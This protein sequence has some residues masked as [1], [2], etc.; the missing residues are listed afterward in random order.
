MSRTL[1]VDSQVPSFPGPEA[2]PL[3]RLSMDGVVALNGQPDGVAATKKHAS[4]HS[5]FVT[6][7]TAGEDGADSSPRGDEPGFMQVLSP[8]ALALSE[9]SGNNLADSCRNITQDPRIGL[10][11]FVSGLTETPRVNGHGFVTDDPRVLCRFEEGTRPIKL[12]VVVEGYFRCGKAV[13][14]SSLGKP[15][16]EAAAAVALGTNVFALDNLERGNGGLT[17]TEIDP[18]LAEGYKGDL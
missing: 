10:L 11:F 16:L 8:T 18:L 5:P 14:R 2:V 1:A 3:H 15:D 12:A 13:I 9:R 6:L 4:L 7:A 17:S